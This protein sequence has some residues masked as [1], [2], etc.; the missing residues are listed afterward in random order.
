VTAGPRQLKV[1]RGGDNDTWG[2]SWT[3]ADFR[4]NG[5]AVSIAAKYTGPSNA[6]GRASIDSVHVAVSYRQWCGD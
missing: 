4:S 6:N 5:F 2:V 1:R 3:P